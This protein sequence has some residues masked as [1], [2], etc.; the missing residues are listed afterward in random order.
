MKRIPSAIFKKAVNERIST[1]I[2]LDLPE[3]CQPAALEASKCS[4]AEFFVV[5]VVFRMEDAAIGGKEFLGFFQ[6]F[7]HFQVATFAR[8]PHE[9]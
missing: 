2:D 6:F 5:R 8:C 7:P 3:D 1:F 9:T 4:R